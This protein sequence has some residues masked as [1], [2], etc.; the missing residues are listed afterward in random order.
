MD[1][2]YHKALLKKI[3]PFEKYGVIKPSQYQ[4]FGSFI[5]MLH[6]YWIF[7]VSDEAGIMIKHFVEF[8]ACVRVFL[9][10]CYVMLF[11][12]LSLHRL[13]SHED[14]VVCSPTRIMMS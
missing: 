13:N 11:A 7:N 1:Y 4:L 8:I 6:F 9:I 14:Q 12:S 5:L 10:C 3:P 2:K